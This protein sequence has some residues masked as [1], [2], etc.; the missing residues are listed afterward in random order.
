LGGGSEKQRYLDD[1]VGDEV[2]GGELP[3]GNLISV[4]DEN[5]TIVEI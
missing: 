4:L 1:F 3:A 2:D 5:W